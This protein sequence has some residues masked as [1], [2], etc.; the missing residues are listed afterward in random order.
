MYLRWYKVEVLKLCMM[1]MKKAW[2]EVHVYILPRRVMKLANPFEFIFNLS[3]PLQRYQ[4]SAE[5]H[6]ECFLTQMP[7]LQK[8]FKIRVALEHN[9]FLRLKEGRYH[10]YLVHC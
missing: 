1:T 6:F 3:K 8:A 2:I 9:P 7:E 5:S 4:L 10:K